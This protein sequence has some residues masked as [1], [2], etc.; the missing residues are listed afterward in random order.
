MKSIIEDIFQ[1]LGGI[2]PIGNALMPLSEAEVNLIEKTL[3]L[4]LPSDYREFL[5]SYGSSSFGNLVEFQT[6]AG[7]I[8]FS[9]FYGSKDG[10]QDLGKR[11]KTYQGRMPETLIPIA[12]DGGGNQICIG[13]NGNEKGKI[14]YWDHDN[15]WDSEDY[16]E[17]HGIQMPSELKFQNVILVANSFE[18]FLLMLE[19][20]ND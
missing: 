20:R 3:G 7:K 6:E 4:S 13:M 19:V 1:K 18:N 15:E 9:H 17:K 8:P 12:D 16:Y 2:T 14:Y 5:L 10:K 11:I